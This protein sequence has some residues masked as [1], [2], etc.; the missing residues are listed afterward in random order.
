MMSPGA[1]RTSSEP[2]AHWVA[3]ISDLFEGLRD[4]RRRRDVV[5]PAELRVWSRTVRTGHVGD[6]GARPRRSACHE[7]R[8]TQCRS[9]W[10]RREGQAQRLS[11]A[12][13]AATAAAA[14]STTRDP[15]HRCARYSP[16][17]QR[18]PQCALSA[19]VEYALSCS[20][21]PPGPTSESDGCETI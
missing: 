9:V 16:E 12:L 7:D 4:I 18:R 13:V 15:R 11:F 17:K 6:T 8:L 1:G 20:R 2:Q 19:D 3:G 10:P 5:Q 21:N 14:L